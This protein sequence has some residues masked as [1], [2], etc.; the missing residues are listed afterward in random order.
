MLLEVVQS[1]P[2][3]V[4]T[5]TI[6]SEA[7][8]HHFRTTFRFFIMNAFLVTSEVVD[9]SKPFFARTVRFVTFE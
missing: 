4:G 7:E 2:V 3:L 6:L 5:G 9:C 1:R 8:V